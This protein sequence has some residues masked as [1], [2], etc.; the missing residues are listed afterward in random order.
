VTF[1]SG[2]G[3]PHH[4]LICSSCGYVYELNHSYLDELA[5]KVSNDFGF[6]PDLHHFAI[7]GLCKECRLEACT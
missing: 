6:A 2:P 7:F 3:R 5:G 1:C 4:H